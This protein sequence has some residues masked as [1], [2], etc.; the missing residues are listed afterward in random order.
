MTFLSPPRYGTA[1][2]VAVCGLFWGF[3]LALAYGA[4]FA[5]YAI[6]RSS[7]QIA[8]VL[9]DSTALWGTLV[10]NALSI[11]LAS[12]LFALLLG[13]GAAVLQSIA[14]LFV[15]AVAPFLN[16]HHASGRGAWIG[17]CVSGILAC[18][19]HFVVQRSL[20]SYF[21]A[22]WP[23]GYFFW[24]GLPSLLFMGTTS[25]LSWRF[26]HKER[27]DQTVHSLDLERMLPHVSH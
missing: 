4:S 27:I 16:S 3:G 14:L 15:Y 17:L 7:S 18:A 25:W 9:A 19:L 20:G 8:L 12:L 24:L 11:L 5:L 22:L 26:R 1:R 10:A 23:A 13:I 21:A 6:I 2:Q